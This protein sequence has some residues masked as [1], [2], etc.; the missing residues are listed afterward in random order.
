MSNCDDLVNFASKLLDSYKERQNAV[1]DRA[2][3]ETLWTDVV[4][5]GKHFYG[6]GFVIE[7]RVESYEEEGKGLFWNKSVSHTGSANGSSSVLYILPESEIVVAIMGNLTGINY[8]KEAEDIALLIERE[9][10]IK[11]RSS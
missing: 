8:Q 4:S 11:A 3:V 9:M 5:K 10:K 7:T 2:T 1:L 6:L